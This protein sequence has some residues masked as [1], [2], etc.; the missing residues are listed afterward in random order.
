MPHSS[1]PLPIALIGAG[2]IGRMHVER[3]RQGTDVSL[4]GITDNTAAAEAF[5]R[6]SNVPYFTDHRAMLDAVMPRAVL[7]CTPNAAHVGVGLDCVARGITTLIEK[8][9]ADTVEDARRLVDAA[10]A[11]G[12]KL[13]TG[14]H[15]RHNPIIK[16]ARRLLT[17]G[18]LGRP[19]CVTAMATWLKPDSYFD[20]AWRRE[21]GGGPVL[22][23]LIHDID[24]LLHLFGDVTSVQAVTSSAVRGHVVEDTAAITLQFA[25]GALGS[26][27]VSDT[28]AAPWNWDLGAGEAAH[29]AR[30]DV[31]SIYLSG[32][33]A[34]LTLPRLEVWRYREARGWHEPLTCERTMAHLR[35]PY[36]EQLRHLRAVAEGR[37]EPLCS[38]LDGLKTLATTIAVHQA[39]QT[40]HAVRPNS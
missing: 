32:T 22:I 16:T 33:E 14:H 36:F 9:I 28:A 29:Y 30:A 15:R 5:A 11:A 10:A 17:G 4:V 7:V 3:I 40:Q 25:N 21:K 27:T 1:A 2:G 20:L 19:V 18:L 37:E 35:D 8:P 38:G 34:S 39:A 24:L 31:N 26:L 13:L 23:N 12:V 6:E